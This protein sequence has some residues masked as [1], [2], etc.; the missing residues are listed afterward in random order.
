[1]LAF[2]AKKRFILSPIMLC[3]AMSVHAQTKKDDIEHIEVIYKRSS[4]TSEITEDTEKLIEMPGALGDP[5]R[6]VFALPGVVAAGGS[7][8]EPAVRGSS[9]SDNMFEVDF[10]PAGYI[11]HDFGS[12]IFN[13]HIIQ[14]FQLYSAGYGA[15]YSNAT[16]AVFDVTLR[17]PKYQPI[18]TTLDFSMFNAG[19]FVEG[20][21]TET[22]AFYVSGRKSTLPL[23]FSEGEELEDDDGEPSG[24][25]INDAPD[26]HDYQGKFLWDI[27]NNNTLTFNFTGAEDSAAAGFSERAEIAQKT[28]EFQG[29]ARFIR[30]FNSQSILW[31][32]Y[33]KKFHLRVGIGA[34]DHSGRLEFGKQ[35][36]NLS[37]FF[38]Q[39]GEKQLT[40]KA[41]LNYTVNPQHRFVFDAAYF[42]NET[43]YEYDTFQY[44][45]TEIDPDCD[46]KKG[47]RIS[48]KRTIDLDS[49]FVGITHIWQPHEDW[50]T[51]VGVQSQHNRYT[52][53]TFTSPRVAINYYVTP[54][55]VISAKVGRYNRMQDVEYILP[56]IGN[57]ALK[58]QV[59]THS[60]LGFRQVLEDEWSWSIEGYYKTMEDLPLAI[61]AGNDAHL[62]YSNQVEGRAYGVDLL[63]NKNKTD[64]WYGWVALSYAKSERT[65]LR[66]NI[67]RDYYADTP[68]VFN[69]V[70]NYDINELWQGGFNFTARSGQAYTPIVGVRENP[71][72]AGR[73]LPVYGDPFSERFKTYHRLDV[74]FERKTTVFGLEGKLIL[75]LMNAYGQDNVAYIDLDYDKITSVNDLHIKE[76]N[77]DFEMRP[78]IGFSV[79]F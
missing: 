73:F 22:T 55:S 70:L 40:Y 41:R 48:G 58:S 6:A 30:D 4:I 74:R 13:R 29:D 77:D 16:G 3:M 10:M 68:L 38:E 20:Q 27:N 43:S 54:N 46:L 28:P 7:M 65:D 79:T 33:S 71:D 69:A 25:T 49:G 23:F 18:T 31:D 12:S 9:P 24:V 42:D 63:V 35:P 75:E 59:A 39:E 34:L 50:Q 37:G 15:G 14:D 78:S 57:P 8:S 2:T 1:M 36:N 44:L 5:L 62:L 56:E 76:E 21:A 19:F 52:D 32:H 72:H 45:C 47:E 60:T 26:D 17:N 11:F 61:D 51:E 67:T 64:N 66:R 53:E